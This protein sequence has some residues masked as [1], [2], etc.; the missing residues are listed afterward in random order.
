MMM[1]R[2]TQQPS[3]RLLYV[4]SVLMDFSVGANTLLLALFAPRITSRESVIGMLGALMIFARI[5]A[6]LIAGPISDRI[7][8]RPFMMAAGV[9]LLAALWLLGT[10]DAV[11]ELTVSAI[12][13][14]CAAGLIWFRVVACLAAAV[15]SCRERC[16]FCTA[17]WATRSCLGSCAECFAFRFTTCIAECVDSPDSSTIDSIS[18]H[19]EWN[20]PPR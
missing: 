11:W 7:G 2:T 19:R 1:N 5:P 14:G 4:S 13:S 12:L 20:S 6:N 10:A 18:A 3:S 17:G 15:K 8:R 9:M 16:R